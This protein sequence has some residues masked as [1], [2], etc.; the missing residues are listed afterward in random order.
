MGYIAI[1][2]FLVITGLF[3]WIFPG[4]YNVLYYGFA[5]LEGFFDFTP[6]IFLFLIPAITMRTFSEELN[7]GTIEILA[8]KPIS[9]LG[10]ILGKYFAA[11]LLVVFSLLFTLIYVFTIS[12]L[13]LPA[14]DIDTGAVIGSYIG[15]LF[16]GGCFVSLGIFASTLTGNQIVAFVIGIFLCFFTFFG[17]DYISRLSEFT[18]TTDYL[19]RNLGISEH[20]RSIS[21]GVLDTRDLIYFLSF[22][23]I[24]LTASKTVLESRKW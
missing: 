15:L 24:F 18:G 5:T 6:I 23:T 9:D 17:F 19:I 22:I 7:S 3:L 10:I 8:T 16:I 14:G 4:D 11:L 21:R 12:T 1:I 13:A 2:V 20:Y